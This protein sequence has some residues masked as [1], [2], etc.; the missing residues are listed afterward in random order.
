MSPAL[1][2]AIRSRSHGN[3]FLSKELALGLLR[4]RQAAVVDGNAELTA[5]AYANG[6]GTGVVDISLPESLQAFV[7]ARVSGL[8]SDLLF[9]AKVAA[10]IGATL[11]SQRSEW[12]VIQLHPNLQQPTH[13]IRRH[14][15]PHLEHLFLR[16]LTPHQCPAHCSA[17]AQALAWPH[18]S[19]LVACGRSDKGAGIVG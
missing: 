17:T 2:T 19:P 18:R 11:A 15:T 6:T 8:P 10:C 5:A 16:H 4:G 9:V 12:K 13:H 14:I 7:L 3:P 1:F